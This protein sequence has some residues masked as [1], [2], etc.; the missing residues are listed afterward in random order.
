[1]AEEAAAACAPLHIYASPVYR[2]ALSVQDVTYVLLQNA[3]I[4]ATGKQH[5]SG[6]DA[7]TSRLLD[8]TSDS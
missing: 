3:L 7:S 8:H 1:M 2:A 6:L 4:R 5:H